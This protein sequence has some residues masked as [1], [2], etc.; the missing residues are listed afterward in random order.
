MK[1]TIILI[2]HGESEGNKTR[3]FT[4]H[5]NAPLTELGQ[6]QAR[7][8]A[9]ALKSIHID[10]IYTSDLCRAHDT[11]LPV[12]EDHGLEIESD[13]RLREIY[14][15]EWESVNFDVLPQKYPE[16]FGL[17][18]ANIGLSRCTGGESIVELYD[19]VVKRVIEIA[20][21]NPGKTVCIATHATPVRAVCA[22]ASGISAEDI[23]KEPFPGN[24][25]ISIVEY[26]NGKLTATV[27]GDIAHLNGFETFLPDAV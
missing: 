26:E 7:L 4:G 27:K 22:Y 9:D 18:K 24:A 10:R 3:V 5:T 8:A 6:L 16:D 14:G 19:R 20:E 12:A 13:E 17:W 23:S 21:E 2:R 25:S 1:T 11:G 15:G